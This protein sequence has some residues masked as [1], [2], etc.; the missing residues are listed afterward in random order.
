MTISYSTS[1]EYQERVKRRLEESG[2]TGLTAFILAHSGIPKK[3][4]EIASGAGNPCGVEGEIWLNVHA[5]GSTK[6]DIYDFNGE[7]IE[8]IKNVISKM[9]SYVR[10][11]YSH[12]LD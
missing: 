10:E 12:L 8:G 9:K 4:V 2:Y 6:T 3:S 7:K 1:P 11:N 5:F